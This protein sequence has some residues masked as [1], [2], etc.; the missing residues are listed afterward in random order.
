MTDAAQIAVSSS[1]IVPSRSVSQR[2][3]AGLKKRLGPVMVLLH[4]IDEH[5]RYLVFTLLAAFVRQLAQRFVE[6]PAGPFRTKQDL[7]ALTSL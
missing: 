7:R 5:E 4:V 6:E 3:T 1:V 2:S